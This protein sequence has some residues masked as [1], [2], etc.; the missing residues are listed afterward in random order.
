M[1]TKI[2]CTRCLKAPIIK[3]KDPIFL[4]NETTQYCPNCETEL[5]YVDGN[6]FMPKYNSWLIR[7]KT[8]III[9]KI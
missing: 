6:S 4:E 3:L 1:K 7:T 9:N 8:A 5:A 2:K